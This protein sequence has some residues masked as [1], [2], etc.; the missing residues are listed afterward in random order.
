[1]G[2]KEIVD[3]WIRV[4]KATEKPLLKDYGNILKIC[5]AG[6]FLIGLIAFIIRF[7]VVLYLFPQT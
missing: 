6:L 2:L 1:M 3:S 7:I 4:I 5:L